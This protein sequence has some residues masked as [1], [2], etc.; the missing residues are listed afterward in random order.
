[1]IQKFIWFVFSFI[2]ISLWFWF[3]DLWWYSI[4][5]YHVDMT[6]YENAWMD[7]VETIEVNFTEP[8]HG[9]YRD[10]PLSYGKEQQDYLDIENISVED[11][12]LVKKTK[13]NQQISLQIWDPNQTFVG[14]KQYVIRYHINNA[15]WVYSGWTELYRNVVG[16]EWNTTINQSSWTINLPKSYIEN[17]GSVFALRGWYGEKK[18]EGILF[19]KISDITWKWRLTT[20]LQPNQGITIGMKFDSDYFWF[21][22]NYNSYKQNNTSEITTSQQTISASTN[23]SNILSS[24]YGI[25]PFLLIFLFIKLIRKSLKWEAR[26]SDRPVTIYYDPPKNIDIN[27]AFY[28]WYNNLEQPRVF[29]ALVYHRASKWWAIIKKESL[30]GIRK[31]I[32]NDKY[33][34]IETSNNPQWASEIDKILLQDFFWDFDNTNDKITLDTSSHTTI[35]TLLTH[36]RDSFQKAGLTQA[37]KWFLGKLWF[38]ELNETGK[39][40]FEHMRGWKKYLMQV[41]KPVLEMEIKNNPDFINKILP[42]AVLF[43]V[44]TRLLKIMEEVLKDINRYQSNDGTYL[45]AATFIAMNQSFKTYSMPPQSSHSSGFGGWGSSWWWGG[46]GWGGSW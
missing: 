3:A 9:I 20:P 4:D 19:K 10:I 18:T 26:K 22:N 40:I 36:L 21:P 27:L 30:G 33:H 43:G 11:G 44:E 23:L 39:D 45:T 1:M 6:L 15:I 35:K 8:R 37:R 2:F 5:N 34:I 17:T 24:I 7:I 29:M 41:E 28:F 16:Q 46:W 14:A 42:W 38:T 12:L 13:N 31:W 25:V 32:S